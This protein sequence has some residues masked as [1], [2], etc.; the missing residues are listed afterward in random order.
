MLTCGSFGPSPRRGDGGIWSRMFF[1]T[2]SASQV[3]MWKAR[4]GMATRWTFWWGSSI[5]RPSTGSVVWG[6]LPIL[7]G[8]ITTGDGQSGILSEGDKRDSKGDNSH[9][10][11]YDHTRRR[12]NTVRQI[13]LS[14]LV[15]AVR[16]FAPEP[17]SGT[18]PRRILLR[19][20]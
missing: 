15:G 20:T 14:R 10:R 2:S 6:E 11:P 12:P 13:T 18:R 9:G 16:Y 1:T 5:P 7:R 3:S 8:S 19:F 17:A 4:G